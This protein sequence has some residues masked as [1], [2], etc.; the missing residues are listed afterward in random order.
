[1]ERIELCL[2]KRCGQ[3]TLRFP[4]YSQQNKM[5]FQP[6]TLALLTC[7]I[8]SIVIISMAL[9]LLNDYWSVPHGG[10]YILAGD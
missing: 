5:I 7:I 9:G 4:K 10:V 2:L 8:V 3:D 6:T 1:M